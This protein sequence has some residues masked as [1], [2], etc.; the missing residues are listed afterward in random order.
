MRKHAIRCKTLTHCS[1]YSSAD[2]ERFALHSCHEQGYRNGHNFWTLASLVIKCT[3]A[4]GSIPLTSDQAFVA[5][6]ERSPSANCERP[7]KLFLHRSYRIRESIMPLVESIVTVD[8]EVDGKERLV[9]HEYVYRSGLRS[10]QW[11]T[12]CIL[13]LVIHVTRLP[14]CMNCEVHKHKIYDLL[15]LCNIAAKG[16]KHSRAAANRSISKS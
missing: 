14:T 5:H 15:M 10:V 7:A 16:S 1:T 3:L 4:I 13:K 11:Y 8:W 9:F 2:A 6:L 12:I